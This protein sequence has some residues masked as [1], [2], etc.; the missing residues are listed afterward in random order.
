MHAYR[1]NTAKLS[2][3][4][5][6]F[7]GGQFRIENPKN[8][9]VLQ[10]KLGFCT[11]PK[12]SQKQV[13]IRPEWLAERKL[14]LK[15]SWRT[16]EEH[17]EKLSLEISQ[18]LIPLD[19]TCYYFQRAYRGL[20]GKADREERIKLWTTQGEICRFYKI[21]DPLILVERGSG[22]VPSSPPDDG[23]RE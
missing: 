14:V 5:E 6:E 13:V 20:K 7:A 2:R 1:W 8:G 11:I 4:L 10:G 9:L 15:D 17:W 23:P 16:P 21:K 22:F 18:T 3:K 12:L 19:Y